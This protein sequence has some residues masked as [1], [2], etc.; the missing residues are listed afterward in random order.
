MTQNDS[1]NQD[2]VVAVVTAVVVV[3][4]VGVFYSLLAQS[5]R[6]QTQFEDYSEIVVP[7]VPSVPNEDPQ[8]NSPP[9]SKEREFCIQVVTPAYNPETGVCIDFGTPCDVPEGW[10]VGE[11]APSN[12]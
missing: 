10:I 11:C 9:F 12:L 1:S 6:L 2:K 5:A 8:V 7:I 4:A 3:F